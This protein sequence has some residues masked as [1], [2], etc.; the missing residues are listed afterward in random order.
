VRLGAQDWKADELLPF[1]HGRL[2][3]YLAELS[4]GPVRD[5]IAS[6]FA[7]RN[8]ISGRAIADTGEDGKGNR[9]GHR[10]IPRLHC[11]QEAARP[12]GARGTA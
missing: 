8:V 9:T 1:V 3:P 10:A 4:G 12:I 2:I 6:I 7:E 5:T 11:R